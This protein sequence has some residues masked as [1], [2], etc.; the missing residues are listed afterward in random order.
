MM[1]TA[2]AGAWEKILSKGY[3]LHVESMSP[4]GSIRLTGEAAPNF[5]NEIQLLCRRG[6]KVHPERRFP[7]ESLG[8]NISPRSI[9]TRR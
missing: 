6:K 4:V 2:K 1:A 8:K 3:D 9:H 7:V 5:L